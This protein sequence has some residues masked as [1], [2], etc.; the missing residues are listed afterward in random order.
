MNVWPTLLL[1]ASLPVGAQEASLVAQADAAYAKREDVPQAKIA[2][3]TYERAAVSGSTQAVEC[4]WKASRAAWWLGEH[5]QDRT[6]RMDYY[7]KGVELDRKALAIEPNSI[8]AHYWLGCNLGSYGDTKGVLKSLSLVKPIRHE[9]QEV[10]RLDD[11]YSSGGAWQVLGVVD[12]K[13][14]GL[15]GGSKS[16]AKQELEKALAIGPNDPFNNY[17]MAEFYQTTGDHA[18][19]KSQIENLHTLHVAPD[20]VPELKMLQ[21]RAARDLQ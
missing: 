11:H 20:D 8:A 17:Y 15:M 1:F 21:A 7:Q 3:V 4:Y 14:P 9:M 19:K 2:M 5:A 12:Y 6:E 16:R 10:I 18:K 13:V